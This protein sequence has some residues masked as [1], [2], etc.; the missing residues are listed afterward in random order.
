[1]WKANENPK[2]IIAPKKKAKKIIFSSRLTSHL[3]L[4][5]KYIA[6]PMNMIHPNKCVLQLHYLLYCK[7]CVHSVKQRAMN[8]L[9]ITYQ[10]FPVSVCSRKI[11]LKQAVNDSSG[12]RCPLCKKS[13]SCSHFGKLEK[14]TTFHEAF[15]TF[16][17]KTS[18][19]LC[20]NAPKSI[21][22]DKTPA[23]KTSVILSNEC[24]CF[25][26]FLSHISVMR[27]KRNNQHKFNR[28]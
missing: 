6:A 22:S 3:G 11:D 4:N 15:H 16:L 24:I 5:R 18:A 21:S 9:L 28:L 17:T 1:V 20:A 25:F 7:L 23:F 10:M 8:Y 26:L 19:R 27:D 14:C 2:H 13:L 12:G